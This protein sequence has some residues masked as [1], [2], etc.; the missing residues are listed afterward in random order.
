M[1]LDVALDLPEVGLLQYELTVDQYKRKSDIIGTWVFIELKKK[2]VLGLVLNISSDIQNIKIKKILRVLHEVPKMNAEWIALINF[3]SSYYH[4]SIGQVVFSC[5]PNYLLNKKI[6]EMDNF[7]ILKNE[8]LEDKKKKNEF[9]MLNFKNFNLNNEQRIAVEEIQK[10]KKPI[11]LNGVTGSGKTR[12]YI[13]IIKK[14]LREHKDSQILFLVPEI[15][16]TPQLEKTFYQNFSE[17]EIGVFNSTQPQKKR[18]NI[19]LRSAEGKLRIVLGTRMSILLP[20]PN[21]K[22]IVVDEEHDSSYKQLEGMKYSARDLAVWRATKANIKI[23]LG[24]ATP[25]PETILQAQTEKYKQIELKKQATGSPHAEIKI[26]KKTKQTNDYGL[27]N[28]SIEEIRKNLKSGLQTIIFL[29]R[30]G[31]APV[32]ICNDCSCSIKCDNCSSHLVAHKIFDNWRLICHFCG[33]KILIPKNCKECESTNF[34]TIGKGTQRIEENIIDLFPEA[35]VL[36]IDRQLVRSRKKLEQNLKKIEKNEV[37]IIIGTQILTK[38]HDFFNVNLVIAIEVDS[39]LKNP[40]FRAPEK[41]FQSLI[42]V[43]GRAG[44]H[45]KSTD[46]PARFFVESLDY[47][48]DFFVYLKNHNYEGFVKNLLKERKEQKLPPFNNLATIKLSH[49]SER[50]LN[51]GLNDLLNFLN[52]EQ[53]K[54]KSNRVIVNGPLPVYPRKLKNK[55]RGQ[56]IIESKKRAHIHQ[57]LSVAK[58]QK[59]LLKKFNS[60]IDIDPLEI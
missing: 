31:W 35:K 21:L 19:W 8:N 46:S 44:R 9:S 25:S 23:I 12:V 38:G 34:T 55:F 39:Y 17:L 37:D 32:V 33:K 2:I 40:N 10:S 48:N 59:K 57:L 52:A 3:S 11:L 18:C 29:N 20:L 5:F 45:K 51:E 42:Q 47:K 30:K 36:R 24:S 41:L 58:E 6:Y 16:L 56:L 13:E 49:L 53:E 15:G 4:R 28:E 1:I 60:S 7:S 26:I 14:I 43:S 22:L 50:K 54:Y 27:S